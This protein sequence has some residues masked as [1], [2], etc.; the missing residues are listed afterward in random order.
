MSG[1]GTTSEM[2]STDELDFIF[3][4]DA[5][6]TERTEHLIPYIDE[7]YAAA[8][9]IVKSANDP[10]R[11]IY[12]SL[13][14]TPSPN[15]MYGSDGVDPAER[16]HHGG[17]TTD[18]ESK[19]SN[20]EEFDIDYGVLQPTLNAL[21]GTVSDPRIAIALA[22]AYNSWIQSEFLD[23]SDKLYASILVA[24][25]MHDRAAEEIDRLAGVD[26]IAAVWV[27]LFGA[28]TEFLGFRAYNGEGKV[29]GLAPYGTRDP[30]TE[31]DLRQVV[32]TGVDYDVSGFNYHT[33]Q[34]VGR[35]ESLFDQPR[36]DV[37]N[38]GEDRSYSADTTLSVP[39]P[40]KSGDSWEDC[41]VPAF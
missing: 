32:E 23:Y 35:L 14:S 1:V 37:C 27:G 22:N 16:D 6:V 24:P 3:D 20:M 33:G 25:Q 29:M 19:L 18:I 39:M 17:A 11:E 9:E 38:F 40:T 7:R 26:D 15:E 34:A 21:L 36:N 8:R 12:H 28:V 4:A 10:A 41:S 30:E 31:A 2:T 13:L 5:H